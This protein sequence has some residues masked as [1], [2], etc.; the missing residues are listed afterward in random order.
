MVSYSQHSR[1]GRLLAEAGAST[2]MYQKAG[3]RVY[4][5]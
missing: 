2:A 3:A 4:L 1:N 5:E